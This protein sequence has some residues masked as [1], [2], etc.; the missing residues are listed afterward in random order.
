MKLVFLY[1]TTLGF[2]SAF[3]LNKWASIPLIISLMILIQ[4]IAVTFKSRID[5]VNSKSITLY[6]YLFLFVVTF[7][8]LLQVNTF[9]FQIKGFTHTISYFLV[10]ILYY[11]SIELS[12]KM[13]NIPIESIFKYLSKGV[14]I[15]SFIT[16]VEFISKNFLMVEF[17]NYIP[18]PQVE[19]FNAIYNAGFKVFFRSRGTTEESG[20]LAMYLL[21]FFPFVYY[22]YK[23]IKANKIKLLFS[24]SIILLSLFTTFSAAGFIE[25]LVALGVISIVF[26]VKKIKEG[27]KKIPIVTISTS[28]FLVIIFLVSFAYGKTNFTFLEGI[29]TKLTFSNDSYSA[30]SR[31]ERWNYA[32]SLIQSNPLLGHGAG[33][34]TLENGTGSTNFYLEVLIETGVVGFLLLIAVFITIFKRLFKINSNVKFVYLFSFIIVLVHS[35]VVSQYLL[36]WLWTLLA[37]INYHYY[38]VQKEKDNAF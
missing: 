10:L 12:F 24:T 20:V 33:I 8:Y 3:A 9:G 1:L 25:L 26:I 34:A 4:I 32:I 17:D 21:M 22:Y 14:L 23:V 7:S 29:F 13:F 16:L 2:I 15:V 28:I 31:L 37:I 6:L 11:L 35:L 5:L 18:R 19:Q 30:G 38:L 27:L 36:P